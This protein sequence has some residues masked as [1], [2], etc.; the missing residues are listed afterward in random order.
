M[1]SST[2]TTLRAG[3]GVV[4]GGKDPLTLFFT[5]GETE[6]REAKGLI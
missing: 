4:G 6:A 3:G 5:G 1:Q 2:A